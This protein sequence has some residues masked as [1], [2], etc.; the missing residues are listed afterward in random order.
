MCILLKT[1][2]IYHTHYPSN[3]PISFKK[4]PQLASTRAT[5]KRS[6]IE[7]CLVKGV[8]VHRLSIIGPVDF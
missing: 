6:W 2:A 1:A 5:R 8:R 3:R 7:D 4:F